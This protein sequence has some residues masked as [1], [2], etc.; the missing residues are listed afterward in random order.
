MVGML[1]FLE[2]W[3]PDRYLENMMQIPAQEQAA[4]YELAERL[5]QS[6]QKGGAE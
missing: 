4:V 1:H 5:H 6:R 2:I 3:N